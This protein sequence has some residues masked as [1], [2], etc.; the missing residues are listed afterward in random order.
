MLIAPHPDDEA[1]ACGIILQRAVRAR[2]A[3][4]VLYA[5]DG[6]NN[7]WPQRALERKW[8]LG[9][10]DRERWGRLRRMEARAALRVLGID[11]G[12]AKFFGLPDQGLTAL[13]MRG[14]ERTIESMQ[15]AIAAWQPTLLLVPSVSDTH[16]DHNA[17]GVMLRLMHEELGAAMPRL[18]VWS[19]NVHGRSSAFS[20][21]AVTLDQSRVETATKSAAIGCHKTQ[22]ALSRRRFLAYATRRE[23]FRKLARREPTSGDGPIRSSIR[24]P[25]RLWLSLRLS[26]RPFSA[27]EPHLVLLG[28]DT[29]SNR[30]KC[31]AARLPA[32]SADVAIIDHATG[33]RCGTMSF[34]GNAFAGQATILIAMFSAAGPLFL[35][36]DRGGPLARDRWVEVSAV[37]T[38][39]V[40]RPAKASRNGSMKEGALVGS[41]S[42][43][44][45][46]RVPLFAN[47]SEPDVLP[48]TP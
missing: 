4:R 12:H 17:L 38:L 20:R 14:C 39:Q 11:R 48:S 47:R 41:R 35:K 21:H 44:S 25:H 19:Y 23:K 31:V 18:S 37:E 16:A 22:M 1:L 9:G 3:I 30:Q 43:A 40:T 26:F 36:I 8:R 6:E 13:L 5:T 42:R 29:S 27:G 46:R 7:P 33:Q 15:D 10:R 28:R 32:R 2:A 34:R 24:D 45:D